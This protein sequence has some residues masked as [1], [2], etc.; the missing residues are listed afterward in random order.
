MNYF[1]TEAANLS[2]SHEPLM[3]YIQQ[4]SVAGRS[5]ARHYYDAEGW[6]PM[7]SRM[8]GICVT[9]VGTSWGLNVTGGLWIATHMMEH[10][11]YNRNQAFLEEQA[12][13]VLK[14]AAAFS[15]IT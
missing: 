9:G 1:P 13:P 10:Y 15:W 5:A 7:Y 11:A 3:R 2:E 12:Y 6:R 8:P 4:L 14:E